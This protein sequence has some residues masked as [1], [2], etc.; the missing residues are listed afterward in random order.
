MTIYE[1]KRAT[2]EKAPYFFSR[3]TLRFFGQTM[4]SFKVRES[5]GGRA[6]IYSP[7]YYRGKLTGYTFREFKDNDLIPIP[8]LDCTGYSKLAIEEYI[9]SQ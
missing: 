6:F 7:S 1:I 4:R 9:Q 3:D 5:P 2:K 8:G